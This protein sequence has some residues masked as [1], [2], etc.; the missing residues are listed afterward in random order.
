MIHENLDFTVCS[1]DPEHYN[2][3]ST[4]LPAPITKFSKV[5]VSS[6]TANCDIMVLNSDASHPYLSRKSP[7]HP[8]LSPQDTDSMP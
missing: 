3:I 1:T 4:K 5:I 2:R 8:Y 6:L 7:Q